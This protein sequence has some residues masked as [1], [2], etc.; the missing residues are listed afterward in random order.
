METL[1]DFLRNLPDGGST[2]SLSELHRLA[3]RLNV[4][5]LDSPIDPDGAPLRVLVVDDDDLLCEAVQE[6]LE[7][8]GFTV[9]TA[10]D[11]ARALSLVRD[12]LVPIDLVLLD[13]TLG[14]GP[15]GASV[16]EQIRAFDPQLPM[17]IASGYDR[18]HLVDRYP[19]CHDAVFIQK[20]WAID[21]L[22]EVLR[23]VIVHHRPEE[24]DTPI[25]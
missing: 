24:T 14:P 19:E 23:G 17:V 2:I 8:Y 7:G 18:T 3:G 20:P 4:R 12:G 6:L 11:G 25:R 22:V 10:T 5:N 1:V 15:T 16:Y 13:A 9:V 21:Q